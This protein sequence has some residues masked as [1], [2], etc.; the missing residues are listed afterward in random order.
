MWQTLFW[1]RFFWNVILC[2]LLMCLA[3]NYK[4]SIYLLAQAKGQLSVVFNTVS[5]HQFIQSHQLSHNQLSNIRLVEEIKQFS[6]IKLGYKTTNNYTSIFDQKEGNTLW[7]LTASEP[8]SIKP[9]QWQFP[10]LGKLSYKGYFNK[11]KAMAEANVLRNKKLDV[12]L[13]P[14]TAWST[15]GWT[16]DPLLSNTLN[17]SKGAFCE[18][19]FHELFHSTF[20]V[21]NKINLN[22]NLANFIAHK[23]TCLFL[24]NDSV[25]LSSYLK[26]I[27]DRKMYSD[28]ILAQANDLKAY[29]EKIHS[30]KDRYI[31]KLK[32][33][34]KIANGL[35]KLPFN[36]PKK[37]S[38]SESAILLSKN[39]YF[40]GFIQYQ[41]LQDSLEFVFN[42]IYRGNIKNMVHDLKQI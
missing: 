31:L 5:T 22:E 36:N 8:Y 21:A 6:V 10:F 27:S 11:V 15:L 30:K 39:A 19:I 3:A 7:V 17:R 34:Q 13:S 37:Y 40:V 33:I 4:L 28:Y 16:N 26:E 32:A 14:V 29:Y 1:C 42:K 18:L 24:E 23:A 2:F 9:F 41:S 25:N 38:K 35:G 20:Y 12:E